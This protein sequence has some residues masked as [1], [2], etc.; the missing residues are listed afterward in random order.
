MTDRIGVP[1]SESFQAQLET[2]LHLQALQSATG[3]ERAGGVPSNSNP[4]CTHQ[5]LAFT[6]LSGHF[7]LLP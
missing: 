2:E 3:W 1:A 7:D 5:L 6:T 4:V